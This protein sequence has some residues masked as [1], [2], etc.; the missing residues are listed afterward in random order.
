MG[1]ILTFSAISVVTLHAS[2]LIMVAAALSVLFSIAISIIFSRALSG[3]V[4]TILD[5]TDEL[6][7]GNMGHRINS[8]HRD[9][10][11]DICRGIDSMANRFQWTERELRQAN[12]DLNST[13]KRLVE[14]VIAAKDMARSAEASSTAK[15]VFLAN[16]SHELRTP[17]NGILGMTGFLLESELDGDQ[18]MCAET[19]KSCGQTLLELINNILDVSMIEAGKLELDTADF[20]LRAAVKTVS[21]TVA[22]Q[23]GEKGLEFSCFVDSE[24]PF[25]LLGDSRR[26]RQILLNLADNAIKF[27]ESGDVSI[28]VILERET[29]SHATIRFA[30][31]D[32]GI[33]I[34]EGQIERLFESFTQADVSATRKYGGSGLG[35]TISKQLVTLM[36]GKIGVESRVAEGSTFWFTTALGKPL[37]AQAEITVPFDI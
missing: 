10:I 11:G 15:S 12:V 26:L 18:M 20:D 8:P 19:V 36:D 27:T 23:A 25:T 22:R 9:E 7:R 21:E 30:V 3:H 37:V 14:A 16:M 29:E 24:V 2:V 6:S 28:T 34:S 35:L 13:N 4:K 32:T 31:S 5:G 17:M 33:G 1:V